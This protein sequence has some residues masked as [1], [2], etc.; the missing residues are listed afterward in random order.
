VLETLGQTLTDLLSGLPGVSHEVERR[1]SL[2]DRVAGRPGQV[3][4]VEVRTP[5]LVLALRSPDGR[6][7]TATAA[8]E[9][10][11][12]VISRQSV[13]VAQWLELLAAELRRRAAEAALD[14]VAL[15]RGLV[16]LGV[17]E[18]GSDVVVDPDDVLAGLRRLPTL[19]AG[20]V[21][22]DVVETVQ[23]MCDV[24]LDLLPRLAGSPTV[25]PEQLHVV[26][27]TATDYLPSTLR[28]FLALPGDWAADHRDPAGNTP[29]DALRSQLAVLDQAIGQ[30]REGVLAADTNRLLANG[31]F[32]AERFHRSAL[33]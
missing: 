18:P 7:A 24:L 5:D 14:D 32:L 10:R 3:T 27:R 29:L 11:G 12:V 30:M 8:R 15:R 31:R 19:L 28:H 1:R 16:S 6:S 26:N 23:R 22:A 17:A 13:T 9:V 25:S 33:D 21:P 2:G 4:A 20:R